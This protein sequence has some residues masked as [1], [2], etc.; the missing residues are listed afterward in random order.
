M[1]QSRDIDFINDL[2]A[3][4][5]ETPWLEF[6]K[7]NIHPEAIGV[8]CSALSNAARIEGQ[9][10]AYLLWGIEDA[11]HSVVGTIFNP[12]TETVGKQLFQLWLAQ[13]LQPSIAFSFRLVDHPDGSVVMLEIPAA[14]S[15]PVAFSSI[16]YIRIGSATPK[17]TDYPERYQ[18]LI[19]CMRASLQL[20]AKC[21]AATY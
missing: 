3:L 19:E 20:G 9:A 18:K 16:P 6:K 21:G 14:T 7:D 4:P 13:R 17:L 5:T 8:R 12:E 2:R 15:A 11:T 1:N 10:F